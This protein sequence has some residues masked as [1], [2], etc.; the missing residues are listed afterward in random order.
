MRLDK[1]MIKNF[2]SVVD[3]EITFSPSCRILVGINESGKSNILQ[4]LSLLDPKVEFDREDIRNELHDEDPVKD[5][6]VR[7][8]FLLSDRE[9][10][11][12]LLL[13]DEKFSHTKVGIFSD[14]SN[15]A[16]A[17][18]IEGLTKVDLVVDVYK[19]ERRVEI[20]EFKVK[21]KLASGWYQS[22]ANFPEKLVV[23]NKP[24]VK[25]AKY[26]YVKDAKIVI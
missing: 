18:L 20:E 26:V 12:I 21:R 23:G 13:A 2:R 1:A 10:E 5:C 8:R 24:A 11:S 6:S 4:A 14:K 16:I 25:K 9:K 19:K 3:A 7:F 22:T 15:E 17:D